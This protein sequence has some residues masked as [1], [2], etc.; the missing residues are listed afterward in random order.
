MSEWLVSK[1]QKLIPSGLCE[2]EGGPAPSLRTRRDRGWT[3]KIWSIIQWGQLGSIFLGLWQVW[4]TCYNQGRQFKSLLCWSSL[5]G[6][7]ALNYTA[8]PSWPSPLTPSSLT[9]LRPVG[10]ASSMGRHG[11]SKAWC[12]LTRLQQFHRRTVYLVAKKT[13]CSLWAGIHLQE[14]PKEKHAENPKHGALCCKVFISCN[15]IM[16]H[17]KSN[18]GDNT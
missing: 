13:L 11:S 4:K 10:P 15:Y 14:R 18:Y 16:R 12:W 7:P 9:T 8:L 6:N 3:L 5:P 1:H 17:M 2:G